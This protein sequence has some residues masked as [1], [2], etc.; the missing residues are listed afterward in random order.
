MAYKQNL[1]SGKIMIF[2][3]RGVSASEKQ[4][5]QPECRDPKS[6]GEIRYESSAAIHI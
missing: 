2:A 3:T 1:V 4:G 6:R 5:C